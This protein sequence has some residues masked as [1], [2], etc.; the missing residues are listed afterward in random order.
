MS[1]RHSCYK[2]LSVLLVASIGLEIGLCACLFLWSVALARI[3]EGPNSFQ[4][5]CPYSAAARASL[6]NILGEDF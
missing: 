5:T 3:L 1:L 6:P 4:G 2:P